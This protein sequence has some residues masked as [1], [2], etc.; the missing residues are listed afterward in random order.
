MIYFLSHPIQYF[1]PLF[2]VLAKAIRLKVFYY[3]NVSITGNIDAGFGTEV[4]WDLPLL[5][6]YESELLPNWRKAK[7]LN[8][9]FWDVFNP[10]VIK[11]LWKSSDKIVVVNGWTYSSNILVIV[12]GK[13]FKKKIWL[14]A[15][16]PLNQEL[17]KSKNIL[18]LKT[19]TL[20]YILFP[21]FIDKV[22]YIGSQNKKFYQYYGITDESRY[23]FTPY[24][25][26]NDRF[27]KEFETLKSQKNELKSSLGIPKGRKV[28]LYSGKYI[29]KKRPMD[30]L[31]AFLLFPAN[32]HVLIF[33]GEGELRTNMELF[34]RENDLKNVVLTG[35]VNQSDVSKYY[36]IADVF[37]MCSGSG[38]TWGLAVNEAMNFSLP[39]VVSDTT[40]CSSDLVKHGENGLLYEEGDIS[41]LY[42]CIE[43]ILND[44][45][46]A[47]TMGVQSAQIIKNYSFDAVNENILAAL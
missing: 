46:L 7:P 25:V 37:V 6:G 12:F 23:V 13:L 11:R 26:D 38:E 36:S 41:G 28:I 2:K 22:M 1:S 40:G 31:S 21:L 8:N 33:M 39:V 10:G 20:K 45:N 19:I 27:T 17:K 44:S 15:E 35:F 14:R 16:S 18:L 32:E 29:S 5:E 42:N 47:S 4:K 3:S 9:K 34:V 24:S 30:L 43:K